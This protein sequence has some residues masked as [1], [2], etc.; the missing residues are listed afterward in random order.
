MPVVHRQLDVSAPPDRVWGII[1]DFA[2]YPRWAAFEEAEVLRA[3]AAAW[4]VRLVFRLVRA[5][6]YTIRAWSPAPLRLEWA[7]VEGAFRANEG[8]WQLTPTAGGAGCHVDYRLDLQFGMFIPGT[9]QRTLTDTLLPRALG[10]LKA[11]AEAPPI[12]AADPR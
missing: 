3:E 10:A 1:T 6:P 9:L 4:E 7:L 11:R 5:F 12:P 2:A 8:A